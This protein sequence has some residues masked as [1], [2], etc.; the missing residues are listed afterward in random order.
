MPVRLE[1]ERTKP[2]KG[3]AQAHDNLNEKRRDWAETILKCRKIDLLMQRL[4]LKKS[5][6]G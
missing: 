1:R 6:D 4:Q 2:Q 3:C 5:N